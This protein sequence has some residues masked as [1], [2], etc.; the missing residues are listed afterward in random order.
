MRI[1]ASNTFKYIKRIFAVGI[2]AILL[3]ALIAIVM[4]EQVAHANSGKA[5]VAITT[6]INLRGN[7]EEISLTE[8]NQI[9]QRFREARDLIDGGMGKYGFSSAVATIAMI[10]VAII[11]LISVI[12]EAQKGDATMEMWL[13]IFVSMAV[14]FLLIGA[15][16]NLFSALDNLGD[17][18]VL[19]VQERIGVASRADS[20]LAST[21]NKINSGVP[22]D[23][24]LLVE[25]FGKEKADELVEKY[26]E[27]EKGGTSDKKETPENKN[28]SEAKTPT[29]NSGGIEA[30]GKTTFDWDILI[31]AAKE[32]DFDSSK[33]SWGVNGV[34]VGQ[35]SSLIK[36]TAFI[37]R[38]MMQAMCFFVAIQ[39]SL[40]KVFAPIAI[41][42]IATEGTRG[43]GMRFIRHY[44][45]LFIQV[46][47]YVVV[48]A[49]G[50]YA[51]IEVFKDGGLATS[52]NTNAGVYWYFVIVGTMIGAMTQAGSI[53]NEIVGG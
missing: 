45:A 30:N 42:D 18:I 4:Q 35:L 44:I 7:Y 22:C 33:W 36:N 27:I 48:S 16:G 19:T 23:Y 1:T 26:A 9:Y 3:S 40:R 31:A 2:A 37:L 24:G 5:S 28:S 32:V 8:T 11:L 34:Q 41:L 14:A 50:T 15:S 25:L 43:A 51:L 47:L 49:L 39:M 12:Q 52:S 10:L 21:A 38:V 53:A 29:G 6:L 17:G 13:R 46:A 20:T